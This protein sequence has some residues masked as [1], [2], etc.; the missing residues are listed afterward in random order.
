MEKLKSIFRKREK[1]NNKKILQNGSYMASVTAIVVV[2]V[3]VVNF[4]IGALPVKYTE[5]DVTSQKLYTI[6]SQTEE[7]V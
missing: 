1:I 5:F 6:G 7:L 2:L 4:I 3:I